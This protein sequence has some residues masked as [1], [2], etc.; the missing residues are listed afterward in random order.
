MAAFQALAAAQGWL[1]PQTTLPDDAAISAIIGQARPC[2][3]YDFHGRAVARASRAL[4]RRRCRRYRHSCS[5]VSGAWL[6]RS[7]SVDNGSEFVNGS[8]IK[9]CLSHGHGIELTRSRPWRKDD[10][11]WLEQKNGAVVRKLLGYRRFQGIAAA[12]AIKRRFL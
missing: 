5:V 11:A 10:Q 2:A 3:H 7:Y 6:S 4:V 1:A 12:Q 8:L 9:Y